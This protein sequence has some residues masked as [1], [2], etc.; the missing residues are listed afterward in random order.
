MSRF[1]TD[2]QVAT[3]A[4]LAPG[5]NESAGKHYSGRTSK[6]SLALQ[7]VLIWATW[8]VVRTKDTY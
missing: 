7:R 8:A 1:S 4:G 2:R 5:N 3:W 6:G